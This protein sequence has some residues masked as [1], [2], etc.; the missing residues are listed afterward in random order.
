MGCRIIRLQP[1][2]LAVFLDRPVDL[3]LRFQRQGEIVMGRGIAG[4]QSNGVAIG[5][6]RL[7][8]LALFAQRHAEVIV[9][10]GELRLYTQRGSIF[11]NSL[12]E[13]SLCCQRQPHGM[14]RLRKVGPLLK[15]RFEFFH[16]LRVVA[17]RVECDT[18]VVQTLGFAGLHA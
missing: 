10:G 14:A 17:L 9:N 6:N 2:G 18:R 16:R 15:R 13:R 3:V 1:Q 8:K 12:I 7:V 5:L 4:L 11:V